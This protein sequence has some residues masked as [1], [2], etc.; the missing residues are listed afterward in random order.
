LF[1]LTAMVDFVGAGLALWLALYLLGRGFP[2]RI[3][4]RAVLI[5]LATV[6][7]FLLGYLNLFLHL[8]GAALAGA[9]LLVA[10]LAGWCDLTDIIFHAQAQPK[11]RW[12][13]WAMHAF[14]VLNI[15]LLLGARDIFVEQASPELWVHSMD[16][17][18]PSVVYSVFILAA[19]LVVLYN[20]LA[21]I[22][23]R[24]SRQNRYFL[25]TTVLIFNLVGYGLLTLV[26]APPMPRLLEDV[27]IFISVVLLGISVAGHQTLVERRIS[28]PD[29]FISAA[30]IFG[31]SAIYT[32]IAWQW[33]HS[34]LVII[35]VTT[36][37]ILTHAAYDLI[38]EFLELLRHKNESEF[39]MQLHRLEN[40]IQAEDALHGR[41]QEGI[42][43]LCQVLNATEGFIAI[44]QGDMFVVSGSYHSIH[45]GSELP[46]PGL[47]CDDIC[48][49]APE[50]AK[51]I[52]WLAPAFEAGDQ[53]AVIG[54][55]HSKT[56]FHYS[57]DDLD[58]LA[59]A[60]DRVG[61]IVYLYSLQPYETDRLRQMVSEVQSRE[62]NLRMQSDKLISTLV[63]KPDPEFVRMVEEGLRHLSDFITLGQF[64]LTESLGIAG[65]TSLERGKA[66]QQQLIHA[67]ERLRPDNKPRPTGALPREW[68]SYVVLHDAYIE[69]AP[70]RDIMARLYISEGTFN[71]TRRTALRGVAR[72]LLEKRAGPVSS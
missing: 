5:L 71:R 60:A 54:L 62:E 2:S 3:T 61:T 36:L 16:L 12:L 63:S 23:I 46:A 18:L 32:W 24:A 45:T 4:L 49:P 14:A 48:A 37:A 70:N 52:A 34:A 44:R 72:F 40:N 25:V 26:F 22:K 10:G 11:T 53:V 51:K 55:G 56:R 13:V 28:L 33:S 21:G 9:I 66:I 47:L 41:L 15:V 42:Q 29:F 58:L 19:G 35:T 17:S 7:F 1:F 50:L 64:P 27:L 59:E 69:G 43:L 57:N 8:P 31:L 20:V 38:R 68:Y 6:A 30:S 65:E 67:I 39:R